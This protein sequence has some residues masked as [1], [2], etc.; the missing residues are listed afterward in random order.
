MRSLEGSSGA[1]HLNAAPE[2]Q[3]HFLWGHQRSLELEQIGFNLYG[4]N[5]MCVAPVDSF[6]TT[7]WQSGPHF[8][9]VD[10]PTG[11]MECPGLTLNLCQSEKKELANLIGTESVEEAIELHKRIVVRQRGTQAHSR[12]YEIRL[13]YFDGDAIWRLGLIKMD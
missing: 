6:H 11:W 2:S 13:M 3:N 4:I 8:D 1:C 9:A 10:L 5:D 7:E 12:R